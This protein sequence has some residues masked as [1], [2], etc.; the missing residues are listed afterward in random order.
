MHS[1]VLAFQIAVM[2]PILILQQNTT[3]QRSCDTVAEAAI[4]AVDFNLKIM[5]MYLGDDESQ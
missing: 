2:L 5:Y 1:L 3:H 4:V